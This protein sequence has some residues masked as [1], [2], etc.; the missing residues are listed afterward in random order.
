MN[1]LFE[2]FHQYAKHPVTLAALAVLLVIY[3]GA[4]KRSRA[5]PN[6]PV[7]LIVLYLVLEVVSISLEPYDL[8]NWQKYLDMATTAALYLVVVRYIVAAIMEV[9][10]VRLRKKILPTITRDFVLALSFIV[11]VLWVLRTVGG[12]NLTSLLTT[13]AI[14]TAVIGLALQDT[15]G[16][17]FAGLS[18]Q[19][20]RPYQIGDWVTC[21]GYEGKV[22]GINW[23]TTRIL[24]RFGEKVYIP[25][26]EIARDVIKNYS[27]PDTTHI[28]KLEFGVEYGAP[29]NKVRRV[30]L[31]ALKTH[32]RVVKDY[33]STVRVME[34]GEYSVKYA[35]F[36]KI[37]DLHKRYIILA[38]IMNQIWYSLK[39]NGI[40]IPFP[41]RDVNLRQID[42]R[43]EKEEQQKWI[44]HSLSRIPVLKSL[45]SEDIGNL[46]AGVRVEQYGTGEEIVHQEDMGDTMYL[47]QQG[48]CDV[49]VEKPGA[50]SQK[51]AT[52]TVGNYFGEMSLLTGERR[53]ATV[54]AQGDAMLISISRQAFQDIIVSNPGISEGLAEA[55]AERQAELD[56]IKRDAP[57]VKATTK[58][59]LG[60]IKKVFS[61]S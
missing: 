23:R 41:I 31:E 22:V 32:P 35:I 27:Q 50:Y 34:F 21:K 48:T 51:V 44:E 7:G 36:T 3:Q 12:I 15:L 25:N 28:E 13:S 18:L 58:T 16:S 29:P 47:I 37:D 2:L 19:L 17:F 8:G 20:E 14:L 24:T 53:T 55:L 46:A 33:R 49:V 11:I 30:V 61:L 9:W 57:A 5:L 1:E 42:D 54:I 59:L 52:L 39:R 10:L 40:R 4:A 43:H 38:E 45:G 6:I 26:N 56:Q 60:R